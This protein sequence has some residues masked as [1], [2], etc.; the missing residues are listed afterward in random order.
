MCT[1]RNGHEVP[2]PRLAHR[3]QGVLGN[4]ESIKTGRKPI[5]T[6]RRSWA[7][8]VNSDRTLVKDRQI[9]PQPL[10]P[11]AQLDGC[12]NGS[13]GSVA[14]SRDAPVAW[15]EKVSATPQIMPFCLRLSHREEKNRSNGSSP[16]IQFLDLRQERL[17]PCC[18][19]FD[20]QPLNGLR[21]VEAKDDSVKLGTELFESIEHFLP[22][23]ERRSRRGNTFLATESPHRY[24]E[25]CTVHF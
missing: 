5:S 15:G 19:R 2:L 20:C 14:V 16:T 25:I 3:S 9:T 22:I 12:A 13:Q 1:R 8:P 24:N 11:T 17:P 21:Y 7:T 18:G 10:R 6:R 4:A 23:R